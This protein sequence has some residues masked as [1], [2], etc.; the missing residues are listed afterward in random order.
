M[1]G[2]EYTEQLNSVVERNLEEYALDTLEDYWDLSREII[3]ELPVRGFYVHAEPGYGNVAILTD[4]LI[5]D[6]QGQE[7]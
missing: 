2:H 7:D 6:I 5:V 3:D 4:D 1:V